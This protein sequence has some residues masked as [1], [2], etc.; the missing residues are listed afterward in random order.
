MGGQQYSARAAVYSWCFLCYESLLNQEPMGG[1]QISCRA[2]FKIL[3]FTICWPLIGK[4]GQRNQF[5]S[6]QP[7]T[8]GA[9]CKFSLDWEETTG[10]ALSFHT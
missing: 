3:I 5:V 7:F 10:K 9:R 2:V 6:V 4:Q 8:S 1:Q